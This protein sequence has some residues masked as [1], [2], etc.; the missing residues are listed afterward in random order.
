MSQ[1]KNISNFSASSRGAKAFR[2]IKA[3]EH[4]LAG[5]G[6]RRRRSSNREPSRE[7]ASYWHTNERIYGVL[8]AFSKI[9]MAGWQVR[10]IV[11]IAL[12]YP[13]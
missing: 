7:R 3:T 11:N 2:K 1:Q 4:F 6:L 12:C 5:T 13:R 8:P 10:E 9:Y